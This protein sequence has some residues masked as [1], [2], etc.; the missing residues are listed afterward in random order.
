MAEPQPTQRPTTPGRVLAA[1]AAGAGAG[2]LY[3]QVLRVAGL[4]LP[5][6]GA[7][8]WLPMLLLAAA[9]GWLAWA[10]GRTV[11]RDRAAL[12][13]RA[14]VARLLFGK[15]AV[16]AG[17]VLVGGY[18]ALA[19]VAL[20]GWPAPLAQGRVL[21]GIL[22]TVTGALW[23]MAGWFLERSCRIP[24]DPTDEAED[25]KGPDVS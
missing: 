4:S 14:A 12:D 23:G 10:T 25:S 8:A 18:L 16:L 21:H 20:G 3:T 19:L 22:A 6:L 17:S 2:W 15:T 13:A 24:R 5:V 1:V 9:T 11:R 7:S